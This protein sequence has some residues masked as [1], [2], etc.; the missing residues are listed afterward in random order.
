MKRIESIVAEV[1]PYKPCTKRQVYRYLKRF[2]INPVG[3]RQK[4]QLYP[5]DAGQRILKQLGL[6][7]GPNGTLVN[8]EH[9]CGSPWPDNP[10][11]CERPGCPGPAP[12]IAT[13]KQLRRERSEAAR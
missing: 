9:A 6:F 7:E 10:A 1:Q 12:R 3:V 11:K 5:D 13:M 2:N 4:P 8:P